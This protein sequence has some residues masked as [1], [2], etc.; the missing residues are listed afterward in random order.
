MSRLKTY[1]SYKKFAAAEKRI[2]FLNSGYFLQRESI[3]ALKNMGHQV[4]VLAVEKHPKTMLERLLKSCL[5]FKPD[6]VMTMNHFGFDAEGK[7]SGVLAELDL[8]VLVWYLDDYRFIIPRPRPM[9]RP[10]V[11]IATIEKDD[12]AA[13]H[14]VGFEHVVYLPTATALDPGKNYYDPR[15]AYLSSSVSFVGNSFEATKKLWFRPGYKELVD[16]LPLANWLKHR[17]PYLTGFCA[18]QLS[19]HF[20]SEEALHHFSGYAAARA[21]QLY[22]LE[23]LQ[24]IEKT[25]LHIFG[26]DYWQIKLPQA[27][28][29]PP[30]QN[31]TEA[32]AVFAASAVNLNISSCQLRR[33]V[34]LRIFDVPAAGG[35]LLS[36]YQPD[37]EELFDIHSELAVYRSAEELKDKTRYYL[38]HPAERE[39]LV[40]KAASRVRQQHVLPMRLQHL[41]KEARKVF[42]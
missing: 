21:T 30:L 8:P 3:A 19:G 36:D 29:H 41:L 17:R 40:R 16:T 39:N 7:I 25:K 32:P 2:V 13:L 22:R 4:L 24:Q 11:L 42:A 35:F 23:M 12:V 27:N 1:F 9:I 26:D 31:V 33:A 15:Y 38:N 5:E 10:N 14:N 18:Q 34:N 6:A 20:P 28:H 37:M